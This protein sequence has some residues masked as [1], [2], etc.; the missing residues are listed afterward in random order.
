MKNIINI[1]EENENEEPIH[2][3]PK[4]KRYL[5]EKQYIKNHAVEMAEKILAYFEQRFHSV[6]REDAQPFKKVADDGDN[7][8]FAVCLILN[9]IV[10]PKL[11]DFQTF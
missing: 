2:Q 1:I 6:Y 7:L 8:I 4:V 11:D 3:G 10:W 5:Q 9:T